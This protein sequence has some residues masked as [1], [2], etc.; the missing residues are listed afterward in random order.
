MRS[1]SAA[2]L[3]VAVASERS[4]EFRVRNADGTEF[5]PLPVQFI[6]VLI[7]ADLIRA[8]A[9]VLRSC[10]DAYVAIVDE[11]AFAHLFSGRGEGEGSAGDLDETDPGIAMINSRSLEVDG[12]GGSRTTRGDRRASSGSKERSPTLSILEIDTLVPVLAA[13]SAT[14]LCEIET[15]LASRSPQEPGVGTSRSELPGVEVIEI[16]SVRRR[17]SISESRRLP[18]GARERRA[19][20]RA[21][22]AS[23]G[24]AVTAALPSEDA[25]TLPPGDL[26]KA[27]M[28]S[29]SAPDVTEVPRDDLAPWSRE[30]T[31][32]YDE[33]WKEIVG[34]AE[35]YAKDPEVSAADSL[36][37]EPDPLPPLRP[38]DLLCPENLGETSSPEATEESPSIMV[39]RVPSA[40]ARETE[41]E[42]AGGAFPRAASER[43]VDLVR[44]GRAVSVFGG[45][46]LVLFVVAIGLDLGAEER[47]YSPSDPFFWARRIF[48]A[49]T[50]VALSRSFLREKLFDRSR[51]SIAPGVLLL[52]IVWGGF[53]GYL[54]PPQS[55]QGGILWLFVMVAFHVTAEEVFFRCYLD[56]VLQESLGGI[57][58]PVCVS[59]LCFGF[60]HL[61]YHSF[62]SPP[63]SLVSFA[64][65]GSIPIVAGASYAA[66]RRA[67]GSLVPSFTCHLSASMMAV[68]LSATGG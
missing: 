21:P 48:L 16:S 45:T 40:I 59:G 55:V 14:C 58:A 3:G 63:G 51:K 47:F 37:P 31:N 53:V 23:E 18:G 56:R 11:P 20:S 35:T 10:A 49:V 52:A 44:L 39:K 15:P 13:G 62:L 54:S 8:D 43:D 68:L 41:I 67:T 30:K 27:S 6:R 66:L 38:E 22:R 24:S 57:V 4:E 33:T 28:A 19:P 29:R 2:K 46:W 65:A 1:S 12:D 42:V 36:P 7:G 50:G 5:G 17:A 60:Y 25:N 64:W 32:P 34:E 26:S 9:K 61:T